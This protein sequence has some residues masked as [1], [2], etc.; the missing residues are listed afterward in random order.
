[1][2]GWRK[3]CA[4]DGVLSAGESVTCMLSSQSFPPPSHPT[5]NLNSLR[6]NCAVSVLHYNPVALNS[7]WQAC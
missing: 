4:G 1:M 5:S 3:D 2:F 6:L 7:S